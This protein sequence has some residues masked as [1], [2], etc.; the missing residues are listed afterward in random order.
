MGRWTSPARR[1]WR[2]VR[3]NPAAPTP[4]SAEVDGSGATARKV[5]PFRPVRKLGVEEVGVLPFVAVAGMPYAPTVEPE[6]LATS[7]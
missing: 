3:P 1:R 5:G 4:S 2:R 7:S 6:S